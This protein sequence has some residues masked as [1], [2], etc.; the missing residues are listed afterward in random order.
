MKQICLLD[1][2]LVRYCPPVLDLLYN[3]FS[4]TDKK[5][6]IDHYD[7][8]LKTYYSTL[9]DSIRKLGSD[10]N[11]LYPYASFEQQLRK[12]GEFAL[13]TGPLIIQIA[14]ASPKDV[15]NLDEYAEMVEKGGTADLINEYDEDTQMQYTKLINDL[16]TDLVNYGY[17]NCDA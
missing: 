6:R 11:K 15:G 10:P 3:I 8:L 16:V 4:A 1:W 2:Q 14:I 12:M 7:T 13:L 17:V 5:F 9:S